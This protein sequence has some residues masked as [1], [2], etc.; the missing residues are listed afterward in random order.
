MRA[1]GMHREWIG[2]QRIIPTACHI[3]CMPKDIC[4]D[5]SRLFVE[6]QDVRATLEESMSGREASETTTDDDNLSHCGD[7]EGMNG[8]TENRGREEKVLYGECGGPTHVNLARTDATFSGICLKRMAPTRP[9]QIDRY[10]RSPPNPMQSYTN[11]AFPTSSP[12]NSPHSPR[13][14]P[15]IRIM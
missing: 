11:P 15:V 2:K 9:I 6:Q 14:P 12:H 5:D 7:E 1:I 3:R 4:D 10:V 13:S 8:G